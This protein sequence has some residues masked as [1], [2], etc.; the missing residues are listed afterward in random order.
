MTTTT[1]MAILSAVRMND[2]PCMPL[3]EEN[4]FY[5]SHSWCLNAYPSIGEVVRHLD[6]ELTRFMASEV[7]WRRDEIAR[8]V[9][10]LACTIIDTTDDYLLGRRY[11][12]SKVLGVFPALAPVTKV[13]EATLHA[14]Q[15]YSV[16]SARG[17]SKWRADL[18]LAVVAVV[19][20]ILLEDPDGPDVANA[21]SRLRS[22][23][24]AGIP[25]ELALRHPRI[26]GSIPVTRPNPF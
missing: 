2:G 15:V 19:R 5:N 11:S 23:L 17:L 16:L 12:F 7:D 1:E 10:L 4:D 26:P 25:A 24:N 21:I 20:S 6:E 18:E 9:Y 14:S 8:N 3:A 13:A 22:L